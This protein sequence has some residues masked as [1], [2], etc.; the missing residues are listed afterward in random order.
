MRS[1]VVLAALAV[2]GAGCGDDPITVHRDN[3]HGDVA[4]YRRADLLAAIDR[5]VKAGRTPEA[6]GA[7]ARDVAALRAGMDETVA[8]TAE[9]HLTLL[10]APAIV[11]VKTQPVAV[12]TERLATTVWPTALAPDIELVA[13]DGWKSPMEGAVALR[14]GETAA[15]YVR[16]ICCSR[17]S[18]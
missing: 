4:D 18:T 15:A 14:E 17:R 9:L 5:Y 3:P 8:E 13:P 11:A 16:R 10:G 2:L 1:P 6:Y 12:Q 7:L